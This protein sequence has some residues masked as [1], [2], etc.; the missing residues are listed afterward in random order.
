MIKLKDILLEIK[1]LRYLFEYEEMDGDFISYII[2]PYGELE[3]VDNHVDIIY[4]DDYRKLK[5]QVETLAEKDGVESE[6]EFESWVDE[7]FEKV[8]PFIYR[9]GMIRVLINGSELILSF[10][11]AALSR[12][13]TVTIFKL[14]TKHNIKTIG[15]DIISTDGGLNVSNKTFTPEQ[16]ETFAETFR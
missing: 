15:V 5:M 9:N 14:I 2:G 1:K 4:N 10:I 7:H 16:F 3:D 8:Y 13:K 12:S 11:P 6:D